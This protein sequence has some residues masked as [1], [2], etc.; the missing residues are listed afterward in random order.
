MRAKDRPLANDF[1]PEAEFAALLRKWFGIIARVLLPGRGFYI[2]GG[3]A[4]LGNRCRHG[5]HR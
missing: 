2:W 1:L 3:F 5:N 4:N